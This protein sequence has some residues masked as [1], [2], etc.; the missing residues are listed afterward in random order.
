MKTNLDHLP[1]KKR[2]DL[3]RVVRTLFEEFE[4]TIAIATQSWKKQGRIMKV[5]LY[6]SYARG[7]WVEDPVGGY[8]SDYDIL[9]VVSD[10]RLTETVEYWHRADERLM[11]DYAIT[12]RLSAPVS[13]IV[14][15]MTDV[16]AQL[17]S[18]RPFFVDLV[19]DGILLYDG[20]EQEFAKP[21]TLSAAEHLA[22]ARQNYAEWSERAAKALKGARF[23]VSE[24][25]HNDAAFLFHQAAERYYL[26]LMLTMGLYAP[27]SHN[28][29]F[30]RSQSE[31]LLP[32]LIPVW[33]RDSKFARKCFELLKQ[34]YV[35]ARYSPEYEIRPDELTWIGERIELMESVVREACEA[36]LAALEATATHATTAPQE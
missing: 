29:Q 3:E 16:N 13:F 10:E 26:C 33:P 30:L 35:N 8:F 17:R 11:R 1:E 12:R 31:P 7:D 6:G 24:G 4:D 15:S 32:A 2:R 36:H 5:V 34:A 14:H 25:D 27:K 28:L 23:Y 9:I 18:G 20:N 19:R 22:E 21:E